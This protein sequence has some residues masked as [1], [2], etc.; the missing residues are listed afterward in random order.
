M[1]VFCLVN[2]ILSIR[3]KASQVVLSQ[4]GAGIRTV[5]AKEVI[6]CLANLEQF[7]MRSNYMKKLVSHCSNINKF[8]EVFCESFSHAVD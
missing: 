7:K 1:R 4:T 6:K 3:D 8:E 2:G 5:L